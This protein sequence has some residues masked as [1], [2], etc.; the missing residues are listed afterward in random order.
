MFSHPTRR[1]PTSQALWKRVRKAR[2]SLSPRQ[3]DCSAHP[4]M[5]LGTKGRPVSDYVTCSPASK[6]RKLKALQQSLD[7]VNPGKEHT[8]VIHVISFDSIHQCGYD[9]QALARA[10]NVSLDHDLDMHHVLEHNRHLSPKDLGY[11]AASLFPQ[12]SSRYDIHA[13]HG[14]HQLLAESLPEFL[15]QFIQRDVDAPHVPR[16]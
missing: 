2:P 13:F 1:S 4:R 15:S 10:N 8:D 9:T 11:L 14:F 7:D 12:A 16:S 5:S 3:V 6:S